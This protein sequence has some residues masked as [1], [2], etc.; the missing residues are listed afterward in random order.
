[1][2]TL[3]PAAAIKTESDMCIDKGRYDDLVGCVDDAGI[4]VDPLLVIVCPQID[5]PGMMHGHK[6][7]FD[8]G[9]NIA[10]WR[11]CI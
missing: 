4:L 5:D 1:M 10:P 9:K 3:S 6:C 2:R 11:R 8:A 7:V